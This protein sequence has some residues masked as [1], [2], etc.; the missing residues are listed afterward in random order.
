LPEHGLRRDAGDLSDR[1]VPDDD[2]LFTIDGQQG[3]GQEV[4]DVGQLAP[5]VAQRLFDPLV[6]PG[7]VAPKLWIWTSAPALSRWGMWVIS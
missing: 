5:A 2:A 1:L 6:A 7:D 4:D 3:V